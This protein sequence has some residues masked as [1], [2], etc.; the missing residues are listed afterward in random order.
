MGENGMI[1]LIE[2]WLHGSVRGLFL[3]FPAA[4]EAQFE[5]DTR[6]ERNRL[7]ML[8][9]GVGVLIAI[10]L[11]PVLSFT[12]PVADKPIEMLYL[13]TIP[14]CV[15]VTL[16][17]FFN[18][19]PALRETPILA[20]NTVCMCVLLVLLAHSRV[21]GPPQF[22]AVATALMAYV[23]IGLQLRF[24]YAVG[25]MMAVLLTY[26]ALTDLHPGL[27]DFDRQS[28]KL[29]AACTAG[30]LLLAAWRLELEQRRAYL[31][32][33]RE[34][35]KRQDLT[36]RNIELDELTRRDPLTGLSNRRA[37]DGWLETAWTHA[38]GRGDSI[39]LIVI[40]VDNFKEYNDFCGHDAGDNALRKIAVC[41]R[42]QLRGTSDR[43]ARLG[44]EEFAILLPGLTE[45]ICADIAERVRMA[46]HRLELPHLALGLTGVVTVSAGVASQ[47]VRPGMDS[48]GL[49]Q[50]ADAAL[51]QAK[52]FG[53]N[54]VCI[55]TL[56]AASVLPAPV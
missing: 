41:L 26:C 25:A 21:L 14:V 47:V 42:D 28:L 29:L 39:G 36:M 53:R 33:L 50:A 43:V 7:L 27:A 45:D 9:G 4:V 19:P 30:Y 12:L 2:A 37:Y 16:S 8:V 38:M 24:A 5:A 44:G 31:Q 51:Y 13:A 23:A 20:A 15:A 54:R 55:A 22:V 6:R 40:D 18:P 48:S 34:R 56:A 1:D 11:Y 35:L 52:V 46:V 10:A 32:G 17:L 49:F 3:H